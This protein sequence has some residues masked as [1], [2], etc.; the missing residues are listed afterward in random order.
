MNKIVILLLSIIMIVPSICLS[1]NKTN[2]ERSDKWIMFGKSETGIHYYDK[3]SIERVTSG[4]L[5][6]WTKVKLSKTEKNRLM[7][8]RIKNNLPTQGWEELNEQIVLSELDCEKKTHRINKLTDYNCQGTVIN[9]LVFPNAEMKQVMP[10]SIDDGL[11]RITCK[12][13]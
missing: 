13:N 7:Q 1:E 10:E 4:M 8:D 5:K 3:R 11:L 6:V 12:K 9:D 2:K